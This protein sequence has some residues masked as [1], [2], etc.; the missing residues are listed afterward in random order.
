MIVIGLTG[1]I[2]MGKTTTADMFKAVGIP[3][4]SSD[5]NRSRALTAVTRWN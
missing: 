2:G 3:V 5:E 1:S 4:I